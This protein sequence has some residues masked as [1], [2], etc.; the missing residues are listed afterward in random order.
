MG[1]GESVGR[2]LTQ[3]PLDRGKD[4]RFTHREHQIMEPRFVSF[5]TGYDLVYVL[6]EASQ[7]RPSEDPE[8]SQ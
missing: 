2:G 8:Q 7:G 6:R 5:R 4:G 3:L 1:G